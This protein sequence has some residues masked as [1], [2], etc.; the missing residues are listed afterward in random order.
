[1]RRSPAPEPATGHDGLFIAFVRGLFIVLLL[2]GAGMLVVTIFADPALAS[3][4]ISGFGT[5]FAGVL[6]LGSGYLLGQRSNGNGKAK[7]ADEA[8]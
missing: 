2:Y 7:P 6:G 1:M 5:M 4:M 8:A 3:R